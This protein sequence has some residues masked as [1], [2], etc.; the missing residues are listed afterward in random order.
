MTLRMGDWIYDRHDYSEVSHNY[1]PMFIQLEPLANVVRVKCI[2][3]Y[4]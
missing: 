1:S 4:P 2:G 3:Q